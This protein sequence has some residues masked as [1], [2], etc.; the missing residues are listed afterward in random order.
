MGS[1]NNRNIM[2]SDGNI[3]TLNLDT[4]GVHNANDILGPRISQN[5][6]DSSLPGAT[7][8]TPPGI[9]PEYED[10]SYFRF[11]RVASKTIVSF[12]SKDPENPVNWS[13]VLIITII[14]AL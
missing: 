6:S 11:R 4:Q 5:T 12:H 14:T 2:A 7:S 8:S 3:F 1:F 13:K 10:G 9:M